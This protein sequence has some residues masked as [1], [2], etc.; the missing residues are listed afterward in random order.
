M[1]EGINELKQRGLENF[2]LLVLG[3]N[4]HRKISQL[5]LEKEVFL[6]WNFDSKYVHQYLNFIKHYM[7][8]FSKEIQETIF[9]PVYLEGDWNYEPPKNKDNLS[10]GYV[11]LTEKG[12]SDYETLIE[13]IKSDK[14]EDMMHLLAGITIVRNLYDKLTLEEL[15]LL[16]YDTYPDYTEKSRVS[17]SIEQNKEKLATNLLSKGLIDKKRYASLVA[18]D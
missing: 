12:I 17:K 18:G 16:I 9:N 2:I 11:Y 5:H 7:G 10:G 8:P 1:V 15:L 6:L 4:P 13:A 3:V 14:N